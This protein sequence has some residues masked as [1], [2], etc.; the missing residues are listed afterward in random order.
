MDLPIIDPTNHCPVALVLYRAAALA[1]NSCTPYSGRPNLIAGCTYN[2][3]GILIALSDMITDTP[4]LEQVC[5][6]FFDCFPTANRS[7]LRHKN[8]VF[9][10]ERGDCG[11]IVVVA[12]L[13]KPLTLRA[14]LLA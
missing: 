6:R 8:R 13:V 2:L 11:C 1:F 14:R 9:G 3:G 10:E 7:C 12:C 5:K 4:S